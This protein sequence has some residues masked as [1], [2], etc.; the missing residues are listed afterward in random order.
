M[1][2]ESRLTPRNFSGEDRPR[3]GACGFR[4]KRGHLCRVTLDLCPV[5]F[6]C[7]AHCT[8][9][10]CRAKAQAR[11]SK[12]GRGGRAALFERPQTIEEAEQLAAQVLVDVLNGKVSPTV[13]SVA[14]GLVAEFV[15]T[16]RA[17]ALAKKLRALEQTIARLQ[18][19]KA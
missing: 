5:T 12:G 7:W 19:Q 17:G 13:G 10:D 11:R 15:R 3:A 18:Q 4:T 16:V 6:R 2:D 8:C 9:P 14:R 1:T